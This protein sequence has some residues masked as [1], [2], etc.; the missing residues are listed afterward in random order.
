MGRDAETGARGV[1]EQRFDKRG[2]G[3]A[4]TVLTEDLD[5]DGRDELI[6][7]GNAV[8]AIGPGQEPL[9]TFEL[10][11]VEGKYD[12][13]GYDADEDK[14][15]GSERDAYASEKEGKEGKEGREDK[16][17][18]AR[19]E[20]KLRFLGVHVRH[21]HGED[22][23]LFV[24]D[25]ADRIHL[26]DGNSGELVYTVELESKGNAC[27]FALLDID[28]DDVVDFFPS[29]GNVAYS[30]KTGEKLWEADIGFTPTM[31]KLGSLDGE[32]GDDLLLI[33]STKEKKNSSGIC[34]VEKNALLA[35]HDGLEDE[36]KSAPRPDYDD[37][38]SFARDGYDDWSSPRP[39]NE[40]REEGGEDG[41]GEGREE[42]RRANLGIA[43]FNANGE[44]LYEVEL[45]ATRIYAAAL[46]DLDGDERDDVILGTG[47]G[48]VTLDPQGAIDQEIA[49]DGDID[50][51]LAVDLGGDGRD[52]IIVG[53]HND[54]GSVLYAYGQDGNELWNA[55]LDGRVY[56][57]EAL[58]LNGDGVDEL[59][60]G[61]GYTRDQGAM[62]QAQTIAWS[63]GEDGPNE[64]WRFGTAVPAQGYVTIE[65][66]EEGE[67]DRL[68]I[69]S[70][71]A[72]V[73]TLSSYS[74]EVIDTWNAGG[75]NH[76]VATGDLDGDGVSETVI[77]DV[78]GNLSVLDANGETL[79]EAMLEGEGPAVVTGI[80]VA[81]A[82]NGAPGYFVASGY[83]FRG[84]NAGVL[85]A[86][87]I[88]GN[89]LFSVTT[90]NGLA[91][92]KFADL[93]GDGTQEIVVSHFTFRIGD[94]R[95]ERG[96]PERGGEERQGPGDDGRDERGL[97]PQQDREACGVMAYDL[98]GRLLWEAEVAS[99]DISQIAVGDI[100]GNGTDE[101]AYGDLGRD[102]PFHMALLDGY[103]EL[104]WGVESDRDD[105]VWLAIVEG[106]VVFGGRSEQ[107]GG[108]VTL[109]DAR[110]G[111]ERW[112]IDAGGAAD[113]APEMEDS[114]FG[115]FSGSLFGQPIDDLNGDD[116]DELAFSTVDGNVVLVDGANGQT[117]WEGSISDA[118]YEE[119]MDG[120]DGME[121]EEYPSSA[122]SGDLVGGPLT[123]VPGADGSRGLLVVTG[124][125]FERFGSE[126]FAF[127]LDTGN[128][129][130]SMAFDE[131]IVD[132][133]AATFT[134]EGIVITT[135]YDTYGLDIGA[136][137]RDTDRPRPGRDGYDD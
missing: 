110:D 84:E 100:D 71:D 10:P 93:N 16:G 6:Y 37:E 30:G 14:P 7:G 132:V 97:D 46:Y 122:R 1:F 54:Q 73:H 27:D 88:D 90:P 75:M 57:Y 99:C 38:G 3:S 19:A 66:M 25:S 43:A 121:R 126:A 116:I 104:L 127:D 117:L 24:L 34:P 119:P 113:N 22:G 105:T 36:G 5:G 136:T 59:I 76:A 28:G 129:V 115:S 50:R 42:G 72:K 74:G 133:A 31:V 92:A 53:T 51:I 94:E 83:A 11:A 67:E 48:L 102:G 80:D 8:V 78:Y 86:F 101:V 98:D 106:G 20:E 23:N 52:E 135:A 130:G 17:E 39:G 77:G 70:G 120:A 56:T 68:Y 125:D 131:L 40:G 62:G 91:E 9:W 63:I 137:P 111:M 15:E 128:L 47:D 89:T 26:V 69:T 107:D 35:M 95:E 12:P 96:T 41:R 45:E 4:W 13:V 2:Y 109:L 124:Y 18:S 114:P 118:R 55:P 65:G 49:I 79:F 103:G 64:Q 85:Q 81:G 29:G 61:L 58:D 108:H 60:T 21:L 87:D 33:G 32:G 82:E 112:R 123:F 44:P 134:G